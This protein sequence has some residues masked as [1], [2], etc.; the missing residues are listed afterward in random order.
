MST[1][2]P[3]IASKQ[4]SALALRYQADIRE[5]IRD[6][7]ALYLG[8]EDRIIDGIPVRFGKWLVTLPQLPTV[9]Y[10]EGAPIEKGPRR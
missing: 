8:L 3:Y 10:W 1:F 2:P 4:Q 6:G 5:Q 9:V 7:M